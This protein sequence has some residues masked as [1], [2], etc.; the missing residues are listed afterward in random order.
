M[1]QIPENKIPEFVKHV[2]QT[3]DDANFETYLVG[4]CVRDILIGN[5]PKDFDLATRAVPDEIINLFPK[6][7]YENNFGTV[8]VINEDSGETVEVTPFRQEGKY[9]DKRHPDNVTFSDNIND[10]LSR[11][12]FTINAMAYRIKNS[13]LVDLYNGQIDLQ[14]K[15]IRTV[16]DADTRFSEDPLRLMRAV[17]FAAQLG[18]AIEAETMNSIIKNAN[19]IKHISSERI[20]DEFIK[21]INSNSPA[22][23]VDM[24]RRFGLLEYIIPELLE[25]VECF[26]G[27]AHKYDVYN[28]L[29]QALQHSADKDFP[30]H[31]R[32]SALFHDIGKPRTKREGVNKPTFYG[33]EVVGAKMAKK[34]MERLKFSKNEIDLVYKMV[35]YHMFFSDTEVIT[36]SPVRRMIQNVGV[37][38]IWELMQ[39]RECDRVGMDK[40]EAP[41]RLRKYHAMIDQALRDPISVKQ[42]KINGEDLMNTCKIKP[43]PRMGWMLNAL[44]EEVLEDPQK[45]TQEYLFNRVGELDKLTDKELKILGEQ[46]KDKKDVLENE[47]VIKLHKKHGVNK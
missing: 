35:R 45:N 20:R 31:I 24:L 29:L 22:M 25:G 18:F 16:G 2:S 41:Y 39:I 12:D 15:I 38:H 17:R 34:I 4:G 33:H 42:L 46:A 40:T 30:F 23:G 13:E 5:E 37:D 47:E 19:L 26:Q 11:R 9:T 32:L 7:V 27:G 43:G 28:H 44:L 10:D 21:I 1:K 3:L 6:T 8:F 14:N 36:L